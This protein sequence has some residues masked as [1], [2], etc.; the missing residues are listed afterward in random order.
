M[1]P[2]CDHSGNVVTGRMRGARRRPSRGMPAVG[3]ARAVVGRH[4][5][6]GAQA[7]R[8]GERRA[9]RSRPAR[10]DRQLRLPPRGR[11]PGGDEIRALLS[12]F[13]Q[14]RTRLHRA[15]RGRAA[16]QPLQRR[17]L[18][19]RRTF[20]GR[21]H[22]G[23]GKTRAGRLALPARCRRRVRAHARGPVRAERPCAGAPTDAR[24]T[25]PTRTATSSGPATTTAP[26][27][28][29]QRSGC[30]PMRDDLH[31]DGACIDAE[32][33][34]WSCQY[35]GWRIVRFTP[36]G[37]VDRVSSCRCRTRPAAASAA[38]RSTRCTSPPPRR[39]S[40]PDELARQPLAGSVLALRPGVTGLPE[41][42]FAG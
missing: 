16:R 23:R 30:S 5:R 42:R 13:G 21:N 32:G 7:A 19:P 10:G 38:R 1:L 36:A 31:P 26:A 28:R 24:C 12:E 25:S 34:L 22:E 2:F 17:T 33:C 39:S 6:P 40:R 3:R 11:D 41:S 35:G 18:R 8:P 20:L 37:K 9:A 14:R 27:A 4:P 15:T 29:S